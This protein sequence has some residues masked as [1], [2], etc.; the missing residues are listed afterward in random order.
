MRA[1]AT[2]RRQ[3]TERYPLAPHFQRAFLRGWYA[4]MAGANID[5][6]PYRGRIRKPD[7]RGATFTVAWRMAWQ[8][9]WRAR[10]RREQP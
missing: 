7:G 6:N 5:Q 4:R 3:A 9:G 8:L 1:D 10:Q 2:A